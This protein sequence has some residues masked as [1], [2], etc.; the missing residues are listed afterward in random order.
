[1]TPEQLASE[2]GSYGIDAV[3]ERLRAHAPETEASARAQRQAAVAMILR[4][5]GAGLEALF[6]KRAEH[7]LDPWS[8]H[9]AFP[10][11]RR[12]HPEESLEQ[13]ARRETVEEVGLALEPEMCVGRLSDLDGGRLRRHELSVSPFVFYC[14]K[15]PEL[16]LNY[17]VD[18]VVWAPL[19]FL[20][21]PGNVRPYR[22]PADPLQ[23][24]FPCFRVDPGY[25]I[26]GMTY[27]MVTDFM[28]LFGV[29]LPLEG[30]LTEVE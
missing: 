7:P 17:E 15:P 25:P 8:G 26:W 23:R 1:M 5:G 3:A 16:K 11:G 28:K 21:D 14:P 19:G 12:D 10:G 20:A 29:E 22:Y 27:R 6:I 18:D 9:M 2:I 30:G 24:A 13:I 4:E